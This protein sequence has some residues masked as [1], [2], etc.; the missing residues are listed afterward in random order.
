M[1][2]HYKHPIL[3]IEWEEHK[4]FS[5]D[6]VAETKSYV[7]PTGKYATKKKQQPNP[8]E[9]T[10]VAAN[11]QAKLVLLTLTFPRVRIIWSSSPYATSEIFNELKM[12]NPEP[13]PVKAIAVGAEEDSEAGVGVNAAA[14]EL[15]RALPGVSGKNVKHI[16]SKVGSVREFCELS[17]VQ[18][19]EILG[20]EPGKTCFDF[21]HRGDR[22]Q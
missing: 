15:L 20:V 14:E 7:K 2:A 10:V 3:L 8:N 11:I 1:S 6:S 12:N 9:P 5:L 17:L 13:D 22:K 18:M 19:Q 4:S 16:M 21:I